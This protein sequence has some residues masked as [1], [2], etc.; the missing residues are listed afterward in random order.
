VFEL[1]TILPR[2]VQVP[3][4]FSQH[5]QA[6]FLTLSIF[7]LLATRDFVSARK[8][9]KFEYDSLMLFVILSALCLCFADDF[10]LFYLAIELQSLSFYVFATFNR[11]SEFSTESGLKYFVF[12]AIISCLLLLGFSMIYITFGSTSFEFLMSLSQVSSDS[13]LFLGLIFILIALLFKV[14]SAPFHAWLCDVYDGAITSVTLL[15]ASAP[16]IV[17][18]SIIMKI[19]LLVF[20]DFNPV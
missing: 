7:V 12:G 5:F 13:F 19:F 8:I 3:I 17:I 18:F 15:F 4:F 9:T 2:F 20:I 10:L 16:K 6:V 1:V 14:G 11:N